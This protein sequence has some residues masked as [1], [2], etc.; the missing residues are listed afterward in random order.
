MLEAGMHPDEVKEV[1]EP[2]EEP[3]P[4]LPLSNS[5]EELVTGLIAI[6]LIAA[7]FVLWKTGL[8]AAWFDF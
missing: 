4:I 5:R 3:L 7:A 6:A 2:D 8:L 1:L